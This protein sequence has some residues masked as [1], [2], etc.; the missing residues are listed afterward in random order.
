MTI[1]VTG[2]A[3]YIGSVR[4]YGSGGGGEEVYFVR[5]RDGEGDW[6]GESRGGADALSAEDS[7]R[8]AGDGD[9]VGG[10]RAAA[11]VDRFLS[12]AA[13]RRNEFSESMGASTT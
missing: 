1:L 5:A 3:G 13:E 6:R 8:G 9:C 12:K 2:G 11:E 10:R 7:A 4:D